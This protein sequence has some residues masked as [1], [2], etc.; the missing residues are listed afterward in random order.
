M[1]IKSLKY[2]LY[3]N[4]EQQEKL[5]WI[6]D[7]ERNLYNAALGERKSAYDAPHVVPL[8]KDGPISRLACHFSRDLCIPILFVE[9][10]E[11]GKVTKYSQ[12]REFTKIKHSSR[13][14]YQEIGDHVSRNVLDRVDLA[15]KAFYRRADEVKKGKRHADEVGYP[16]F[17]GKH[18][19]HSFTYPD[20]SNWKVIPGLG[21]NGKLSL[22]KIGDIKIRLHRPIEGTMKQCTI[23]RENTHWYAIIVCDVEVQALP[24]SQESIGIDLG[25]VKFAAC[26]NGTFLENPRYYRKAEQRLQRLQQELSRQKKGS[27]RR[28]KTVAHIARAHRKIRN[29]RR[30]FHHKE[31][32]KLVD[33]YQE[34]FFEDLAVKNMVRRPKPKQDYEGKYLPNGAASKAGLNKS[35]TD[36]GWSQFVGLTK[37]KAEWADR[38]VVF[39]H[40]AYTSQTCSH[41]GHC[42][43]ANR[44]SQESFICCKCG[45]SEN[46]DT[47][48]ARNIFQQGQRI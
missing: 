39:V 26:S 24:P 38:S 11:R 47:N 27:K 44:K 5:V 48:A 6:L 41:C 9:D 45:Y 17:K 7:Q 19:Y 30:D 31:S 46:A 13:P 14:E 8:S 40:P 42:E 1:A 18:Y 33:Q 10:V 25:I 20:C 22:S 35:I 15:Y 3:P 21:K 36:A 28:G 23:K 2:R 12:S 34:I 16:K 29:Q 32:R 43:E 37:E 4:K